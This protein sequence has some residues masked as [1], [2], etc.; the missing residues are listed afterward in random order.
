MQPLLFKESPAYKLVEKD[1]VPLEKLNFAE[2]FE[3]NLNFFQK[4][5]ENKIKYTYQTGKWSVQD[6][7]GH[8]ID[9]HNLILFRILS[10]ARGES[11]EI[12]G[13]D[14]NKWVIASEYSTLPYSK[15]I[16]LYH[17]VSKSTLAQLE[18]IPHQYYE[19]QGVA[20]D[21]I[22]KVSELIPFFFAHEK[23]HMRVIQEMYL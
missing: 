7:L 20:K 18:L 22:F 16:Q 5:P 3:S 21:K 19:N 1:Y 23:H 4:I 9:C 11:Y 17:T 6:I 13:A 8:L 15:L 10:F 2:E 14:E 12:L